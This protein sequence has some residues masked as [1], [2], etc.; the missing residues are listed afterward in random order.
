M[1]KTVGLCFSY[2][3]LTNYSWC[4]VLVWRLCL[5]TQV[6]LN[7]LFNTYCFII[8]IDIHKQLS[9][10]NMTLCNHGNTSHIGKQVTLGQE[11]A[12]HLNQKYYNRNI[13]KTTQQLQYN[14]IQ[15]IQPIPS[16]APEI[17]NNRSL[18]IILNLILNNQTQYFYLHMFLISE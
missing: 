6:I 11:I 8:I 18:R 15:N 17:Y 9:T 13:W 4:V 12:C 10:F 1:F 2:I 16:T 5:C 3:N 14:S 7:F